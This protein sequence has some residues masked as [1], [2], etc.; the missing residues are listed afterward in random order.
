[1]FLPFVKG[2]KL[3]DEE[4][5]YKAGLKFLDPELKE[6]KQLPFVRVFQQD[7]GI[8]VKVRYRVKTSKR[9]ETASNI[10]DEIITNIDKIK[11]VNI[12]YPHM[13]LVKDK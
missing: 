7:S 10:H 8:H 13:H 12:A 11:D 5:C 3:N 4:I 2:K 9:I 6:A 1:M